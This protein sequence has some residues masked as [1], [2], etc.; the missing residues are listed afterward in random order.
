MPSTGIRIQTPNSWPTNWASAKGRSIATFRAK[1][2]LFLAAADRVMRKMLET[3]LA[4]V[5]EIEDPI[6]RLKLAVYEFLEFFNR[7]PAY[8]EL[9]IQERAL[10]KD[11]KKP[12]FQQ[13]REVN[14]ERWRSVYE[15]LIRDGRLPQCPCSAS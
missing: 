2:E 10:F 8:V 7:H 4:A 15:Q 11:R 13:H 3:V 12:T 6:V 1:R 5:G 9:L 14:V